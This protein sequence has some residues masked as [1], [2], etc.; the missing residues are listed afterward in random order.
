MWRC[1]EFPVWWRK[2][3]ATGLQMI[4]GNFNGF[5]TLGPKNKW[6]IIAEF[7]G[8]ER[9]KAPYLFLK[10]DRVLDFM[11]KRSRVKWS[12][13]PSKS[14]YFGHFEDVWNSSSSLVNIYPFSSVLTQPLQYPTSLQ[15]N[16]FF[17]F[18]TGNFTYLAD[19]SERLIYC[20]NFQFFMDLDVYR[21]FFHYFRYFSQCYLISSSINGQ[22]L[23]IGECQ[24]NKTPSIIPAFCCF[25]SGQ[26]FWVCH[27]ISYQTK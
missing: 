23:Q 11:R 10:I 14:L 5:I 12:C 6:W 4:Y 26:M 19:V 18:A 1:K 7:P 16:R 2:T 21:L 3:I 24:T 15:S 8:D 25:S 22:V 17:I 27:L 20:F 9:R 13:H